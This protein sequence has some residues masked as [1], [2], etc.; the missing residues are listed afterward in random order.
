M[1][2]TNSDYIYY[3]L[4]FNNI[5]AN[6]NNLPD[7][8][9][10]DNRSSPIISCANQYKM[11]IVRFQV[12][13]SYLPSYV[14]VV[15]PNQPNPN[16]SIYSVTLKYNSNES[17]QNFLLWIPVNKGMTSSTSSNQIQ[18]FNNRYY[19]GY[20]SQYFLNLLNT[21]LFKIIYIFEKFI[22]GFIE[23]NRESK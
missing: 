7:L 1:N 14:C 18:D 22:N 2:K 15:Q 19:W 4:Q 11:S 12:D 3:D 23:N 10:T 6:L 16:L 17:S 20:N 8:R 5:S 13:T 9:F 21:Q